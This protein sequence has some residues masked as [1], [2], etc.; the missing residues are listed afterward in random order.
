MPANSAHSKF[1]RRPRAGSPR[2]HQPC[3]YRTPPHCGPSYPEGNFGWNQLLSG[4]IGLSPLCAGLTNDLHVSTVGG[5]PPGFLLA[6]PCPRI[7]RRFS[8]PNAQARSPGR[9]AAVPH[10]PP[11][12]G[13]GRSAE[14]AAQHSGLGGASALNLSILLRAAAES[15]RDPPSSGERTG[16]SLGPNPPRTAGGEL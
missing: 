12:P 3:L 6:S 9:Q 2:Y 4:S 14:G 10:G 8:G 15:N 5:L 11:P 1:G 7:A 16:A 13:G